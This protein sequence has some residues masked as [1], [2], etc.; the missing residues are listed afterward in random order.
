VRAAVALQ[1]IERVVSGDQCRDP[2][3]AAE[4]EPDLDPAER[5][6]LELDE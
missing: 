2:V 3:V 5:R 6:R 1:K 4:L